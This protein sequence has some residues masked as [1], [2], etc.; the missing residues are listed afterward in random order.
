MTKAQLVTKLAEA[1]GVSR[2]QADQMLDSLIETVVKSVKKGESVKIPGL[3]IFRLRKMKARMGRN[4]QTGEPIKIPARKKV[5]FSVA[6]TFKEIGAR[7]GQVGLRPSRVQSA[8]RPRRSR[9]LRPDRSHGSAAPRGDPTD[10]KG[11]SHDAAGALL[12]AAFGALSGL[13]D[14]RPRPVP[15]R[16]DRLESARRQ[17]DRDRRRLSERGPNFVDKEKQ[18]V[19][20]PPTVRSASRQHLSRRGRSTKGYK[21]GTNQ[22]V[23]AIRLVP[24]AAGLRSALRGDR[25]AADLRH[26]GAVACRSASSQAAFY[27]YP[28]G[29]VPGDRQGAS[30][31]QPG[32]DASATSFK[33]KAKDAGHW[34]DWTGAGV[35]AGDDDARADQLAARAHSARP[36]HCSRQRGLGEADRSEAKHPVRRF[37]CTDQALHARIDR[38]QSNDQVLAAAGE[39]RPAMST[40]APSARPA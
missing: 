2:K 1:G 40:G 8:R 12:A 36:D 11:G 26:E 17:G 3:G 7:E 24:V 28:V 4:P 13:R 14:V 10:G 27:E 33:L 38:R 37:G 31:C 9:T 35:P 34:D 25:R 6:K 21:I 32:G 22:V 16:P 19:T 15:G 39:N 23:S 20:T 29:S 18:V 5:G 30:L